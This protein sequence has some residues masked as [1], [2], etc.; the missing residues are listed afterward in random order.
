MPELLIATTNPGK[1]REILQILEGTPFRLLTPVDVGRSISEPAE[2]GHTFAEN[3]RLKAAYYAAESGLTTV[4]E[5]SGLA[6]DA[7]GGRPGIHSARYPGATYSEKFANLWAELK[8][9]PRPWTARY[10]CALAL[11]EPIALLPHSPIAPLFECEGVVQG[12]IWPEPRGTHGFGYD[13]IFYFPGYGATFGE[14]DDARKSLV[15]HRGRAFRLLRE[16]L[17]SGRRTQ[18]PGLS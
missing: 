3:A 15:A 12:E 10:I 7:L 8:P 17:N 5:D 18:D 16:F 14:V 2:T 13:P 11:V 1:I 4:A 6:I 9:H